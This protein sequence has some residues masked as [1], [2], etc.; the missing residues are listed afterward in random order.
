MP[1]S[2]HHSGFLYLLKF[3][4]CSWQEWMNMIQ[5]KHEMPF[6]L[7]LFPTLMLYVNLHGSLLL[8]WL[9]PCFLSAN[10]VGTWLLSPGN[11][12]GCCNN[13]TEKPGSNYTITYAIQK[14]QVLLDEEKQNL[15]QVGK[16]TAQMR[17][18]SVVAGV[19]PNSGSPW[20]AAFAFWG[21]K[22]L[23]FGCYNPGGWLKK[24]SSWI[25]TLGCFGC[26]GCVGTWFVLDQ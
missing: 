5:A 23:S 15:G 2:P 20:F 19:S 21:S 26:L 24:K 9:F 8:L 7:S 22:D 17:N 13:Q 11:H 10:Q 14:A 18:F 3:L 25:V 12:L 1:F 4:S 16:E 6:Y